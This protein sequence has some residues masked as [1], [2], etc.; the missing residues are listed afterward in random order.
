MVKIEFTNSIT[1]EKLARDCT[2]YVK[3]VWQDFTKT[4]GGLTAPP[5]SRPKLIV[6]NSFRKFRKLKGH[7]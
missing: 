7:Q 1:T 6:W 3:E 4:V 2:L 5:S